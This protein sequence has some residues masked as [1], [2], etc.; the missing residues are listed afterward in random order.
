[1][2]K[3]KSMIQPSNESPRPILVPNP[4][5]RKQK[6]FQE[7]KI[8]QIYKFIEKENSNIDCENEFMQ[9]NE[10]FLD[11]SLRPMDSKSTI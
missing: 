11:L 10:K 6:Y 7:L 4:K 1:M 8:F 2:K 3:I 9:S 5:N